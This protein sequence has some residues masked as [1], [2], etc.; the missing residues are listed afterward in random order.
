M[1]GHNPLTVK[2]PSHA[3]GT[4]TVTVT[5][6]GGTSGAKHYTYDLVPTLTTVTPTAGKVAGGT[7]VTLTGTDYLT[8]AT[9][10][11]FGAGQPRHDSP[12]D[13]AQPPSRSRPRRTRPARSQ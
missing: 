3:A 13:R 7:V 5:T 8:G 2:A 12:R 6:P 10:V 4:V 1:I 11:T 9:A